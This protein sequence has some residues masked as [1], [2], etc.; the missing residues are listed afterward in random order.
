MMSSINSMLVESLFFQLY[1]LV[2]VP[3]LGTLGQ[4][5]GEGKKVEAAFCMLGDPLDDSWV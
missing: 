2:P 3:S 1:K 5:E 4:E